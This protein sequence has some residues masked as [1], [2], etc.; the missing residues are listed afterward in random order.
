MP[1]PSLRRLA[2]SE[3]DESALRRLIEYGEDIFVERK[4]EP[5]PAPGLGAEV[6][7]FANTLGGWLLLGIQ[8]DGKI[9]GWT[10]PPKSDLQS[11]VG[12]LL[13]NQLDPVPPY[14]ADTQE[15]D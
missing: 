5:P 1:L 6:A 3:L 11:H 15:I 9:V 2:L 4:R 7:S 10:P 12:N 8:D 14:L 13:R